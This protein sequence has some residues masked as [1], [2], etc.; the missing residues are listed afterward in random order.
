MKLQEGKKLQNVFKLPNILACAT[1]NNVS[2][3]IFSMFYV[4]SKCFEDYSIKNSIT[5]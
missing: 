1:C 5:V 4:L 3:H 2:D